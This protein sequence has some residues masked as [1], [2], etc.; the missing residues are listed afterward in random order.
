MSIQI[1]FVIM[2]GIAKGYVGS[3]NGNEV[4]LNANLLNLN[5]FAMSNKGDR[6]FKKLLFL[7]VEECHK[8]S[9]NTVVIQKS[10]SKSLLLK[11]IFMHYL[12]ISYLHLNALFKH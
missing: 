12:I 2:A 1:E 8:M 3:S 4:S 11:Y 10:Q 9:D 7:P 5:R 6:S